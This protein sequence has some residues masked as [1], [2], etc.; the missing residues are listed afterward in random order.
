MKRANVNKD[1]ERARKRAMSD[2]RC[3]WKKMDAEQRLEFLAWA[4]EGE[5]AQPITQ[6][7]ERLANEGI[8]QALRPK[9]K[10][11][12]TTREIVVVGGPAFLP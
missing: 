10:M 3:A 4:R 12:R 6:E 1:P 2:A 9:S 7:S 5:P 8:R 11:Q